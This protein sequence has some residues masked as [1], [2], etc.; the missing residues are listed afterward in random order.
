M[1][2]K[3]VPH[4]RQYS[5]AVESF[6]QRLRDGG[7]KWGFYVHHECDWIPQDGRRRVWRDFFLAVEEN[8][9]VRGGFALKPQP[10]YINGTE[11]TVADWQGPFS[12]GE[13]SPEYAALGLRMIREM[14]KRQPMVYS[15]GH[16]GADSPVLQLA[17]KMGW[18]V[19]GSPLMLYVNK[20]FRF[21]RYNAF[22]R[23]KRA[24]RVALDILALSGVGALGLHLLQAAL[25]SSSRLRHGVKL[26]RCIR[27][28]QF[29]RFESWADDLWEGCKVRYGALAVRDANIMNTLLPV[30]GWPNALKLRVEEGK[31][32]LGWVVVM[33][34]SMKGDSR[35][36][37][38]R[39]GSIIDCLA[40]PEHCAAV[41]SAA[42]NFLCD[43]G[44]DLIVSNQTHAAWIEG[45]TCSGFMRMDDKRFMA[46]SPALSEALLPHETT[47]RGLHLTNLDGH[48]PHML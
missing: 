15:W 39:L 3:I 16:G 37:D 6:N 34:T 2:I 41:V 46:C 27:A 11:Q 31:S 9:T 10:W 4:G 12:E 38:L 45:F 14:Q 23:R 40:A 43:R 21:L 13:L 26:G 18:L 47:L 24:I 5:E 22:L 32:L 33:D 20:P 29:E 36:G 8:G 28:S 19:H 35:F 48:G 30:G 7:S 17:H 25:A 1:K 42:K 44:V